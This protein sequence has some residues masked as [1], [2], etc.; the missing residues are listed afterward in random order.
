MSQENVDGKDPNLVIN[1]LREEN[2][3]LKMRIVELEEEINILLGPKKPI[4]E[5]KPPEVV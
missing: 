4:E 2:E 1:E 3:N 5:L